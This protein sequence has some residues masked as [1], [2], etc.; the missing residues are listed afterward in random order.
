[1]IS[2]SVT[3]LIAL[4]T[5][6]TNTLS[7][8]AE[9]KI[10]Y[11]KSGNL[12][13]AQVVFNR[14]FKEAYKDIPLDVL[15]VESLDS[16]LKAAFEDEPIDLNNPDKH[17]ICAIA[18]NGEKIV[19]LITFEPTENPNEVYI[20]QL[21]VDPEMQKKGIGQQLMNTVKTSLP[22]TKKIL[23]ATRKVNTPA[24]KFYKKLGFHECV[25]VPHGLNPARN[26][27]FDKYEK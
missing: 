12:E 7:A 8:L 15:K 10:E 9:I 25:Q 18:K 3:K 6:A 2:K 11:V 13:E 27:G 24:C 21:A 14:A 22:T 26:I 20:R 4:L 23:L 5:I 17:V 16:F 19:G 1:M